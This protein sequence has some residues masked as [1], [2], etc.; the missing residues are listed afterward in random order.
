MM[1]YTKPD[2]GTV[3]NYYAIADTNTKNIAPPG[4]RVPTDYD[5]T[6]LQDYLITNGYN[7]DGSSSGNKIAKSLASKTKWD[8]AVSFGEGKIGIDLS[9]NNRS[10]F[11]ALPHGAIQSNGLDF[12]DRYKCAYW[13]SSTQS[14]SGNAYYR[15]LHFV[16]DSLLRGDIYKGLG[17]SVRLVKDE[18]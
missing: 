18:N 10:G 7:W 9:K 2:E 3:Y 14:G 15:S 5:W 11:T 13:W 16:Y 12:P 1:D 8:T 6:T 17:L 4:W